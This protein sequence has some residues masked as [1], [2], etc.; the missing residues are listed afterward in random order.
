MNMHRIID[1]AN[2]F[3]KKAIDLKLENKND[4]MD[5]YHLEDRKLPKDILDK[6]LKSK[7]IN[8]FFGNE[9]WQVDG[10]IIRDLIDIDFTEGGNPGRYQYIPENQIWIEQSLSPEDTVATIIHELTEEASMFQGKDYST[11]HN[12]ASDIEKKI[13]ELIPDK[14]AQ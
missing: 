3:Y 10:N 1:F 9:I 8:N 11:S 13:R 4:R 14:Y 6:V 5:R 12:F 2:I 7:I